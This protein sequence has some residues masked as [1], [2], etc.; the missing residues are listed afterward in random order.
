MS[1]IKKAKIINYINN[2]A[3]QLNTLYN[4]II[5]EEKLKKAIDMFK[6]SQED[7]EDIKNKINLMV[8]QVVE[9]YLAM[10]ENR[11]NPE[12]VKKNHEEIYDKLEIL[13]K[14]LNEKNIDYQL[15]GS[16]CAYLKYGIESDRTHDDI[17]I[18]L[19]E[20][21]IDKFREVCEEMGLSFNDNRQTTSRV[22]KNG[23]PSGEHEVIAT[24][25]NSN[26]HIGVFCFNRNLDGT[27]INKGYY[28]DEE[29]D[30]CCRNDILSME[31][32]KELFGMEQ[33]DF[34]GQ[35][36][37]I[38][39]PEYIYKLK[40]Y[41]KNE[42]DK[43]DLKFMESR[44][45]RSKLARINNLSNSHQVIY[46]KVKRKDLIFYHGGA[47]PSF[48]LDE[49]DVLRKS[50]KQQNQ[51]NSYVGFYMYGKDDRESAFNYAEQENQRNNTTTKG[52]LKLI[53]DG[54]V[55]IF[56]MPSFSITRITKEQII[57]LQQ[58]GYDLIRGK[59]LGKTE[60]VLINKDKIKNMSFESMDKRYVNEKS[61]NSSIEE[62]NAI[63]KQQI[64]YVKEYEQYNQ[65][66][67]RRKK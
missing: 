32:A 12:L 48:T 41:T 57:E 10:K 56:Q 35:K 26:F 67:G 14:K 52:V 53:L 60:Y 31:L 18:S 7:Y 25:D 42:K 8:K 22:L 66:V 63:M 28:H 49:L 54:N 36:M 19:N 59:M 2:M 9:N 11:F 24:L 34:R 55:N 33:I 39:P 6:D 64:S 46:E 27:V 16:L 29:G 3:Q 62:N 37:Y 1:N 61:N 13:I 15:A 30:I 65:N 38:T 5:D 47:E 17:D 21:D 20:K 43:V 40:S 45:D 50:Q 23:I 44:I 4:G 58:Q 51:N